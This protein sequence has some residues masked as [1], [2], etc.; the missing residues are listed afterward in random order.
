VPRSDTREPEIARPIADLSDLETQNR[1]LRQIVDQLQSQAD[2]VHAITV[3][4]DTIAGEHNSVKRE[5]EMVTLERNAILEEKEAIIRSRDA[6]E[7][8]HSEYRRKTSILSA[9]RETLLEEVGALK[10]QADEANSKLALAENRIKRLTAEL[11]TKSE[12][13]MGANSSEKAEIFALRQRIMELE[14]SLTVSLNDGEVARARALRSEKACEDLRQRMAICEA[15]AVAAEKRHTAKVA[16]LETH[17]ANL[18]RVL[19]ARTQELEEKTQRNGSLAS[20]QSSQLQGLADTR[21]IQ[22]LFQASRASSS[23]KLSNSAR[24]DTTGEN[25]ENLIVQPKKPVPTKSVVNK[26]LAALQRDSTTPLQPI[27]TN[28]LGQLVGRASLTPARPPVPIS[29]W[30]PADATMRDASCVSRVPQ[31][32]SFADPEDE[33]R[34][35][36][37][38]KKSL[39]RNVLARQ[40]DTVI[41]RDDTRRED[42]R[43]SLMSF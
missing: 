34:A 6:A 35:I 40:D 15:E 20:S 39:R 8:L 32:S 41:S 30:S 33:R 13:D 3:E 11:T 14:Q 18:R 36:A 43:M 42:T 28:T 23:A 9:E 5:L 4:R 7:R 22:E 12:P 29:T 10:Q 37:Q 31:N 16:D 26:R 27:R 24:N 1:K 2:T 21:G 25:K 17:T 19:Q 38:F